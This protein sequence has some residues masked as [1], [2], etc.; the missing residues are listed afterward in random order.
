MP[1]SLRNTDVSTAR[2][3]NESGACA[4]IHSR[5]ELIFI[6]TERK[7]LTFR[8]TRQMAEAVEANVRFFSG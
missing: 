4:D 5:S 8:C 7:R 1:I 6:D 2:K 3:A